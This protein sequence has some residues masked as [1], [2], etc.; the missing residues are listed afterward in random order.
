MV[1]GNT[2]QS[3]CSLGFCTFSIS[4][5]SFPSCSCYLGKT[6]SCFSLHNVRYTS[7]VLYFVC[8]G[9]NRWRCQTKW[10]REGADG[11]VFRSC[12]TLTSV[13]TCHSSCQGNCFHALW[14]SLDF[15]SY[16]QF[17]FFAVNFLNL[18]FLL[19][20]ASRIFH[21]IYQLWAF[22]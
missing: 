20:E 13:L 8:W 7:F 19:H 16:Y 2:Y 18:K 15:R 21:D 3:V 4:F 5:H 14:Y 17:L 10:H 1:R 12:Y 9:K 11:V 22:Q 6:T